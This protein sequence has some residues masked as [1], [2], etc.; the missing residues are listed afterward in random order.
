MNEVTIKEAIDGLKSKAFTS[1]GLTKACLDEIKKLDGYLKA[2]IKVLEDSSLEQAKTADKQIEA[3]GVEAFDAQLLLGIPYVCKDNYSTLGIETTAASNILKGYIPP[4]ESTVTERLKKSGAILLGKTNLDAFGH[5][6]TTDA[7]DFFVSRNPWDLTRVPGGSSGGSAVAVASHLCT[8]AIGSDTGGSIRCPAS[9][10]GVTGL[11]P[12]YGRVS[13]Y[14][15][16]AMASSTDSPGPITKNV[17]DSALLLGVLAGHDPKDATSSKDVV[18]D[19]SKAVG[20]FDIKKLRIGV[21]RSYFEIDFETPEIKNRIM[22]GI[23]LL[24]KS[25]AEVREIDLLHPKYAVAV[26]TVIQRSE[27][28]SNLARF[29][30][31]RFGCTRDVFGYEAKRRMMLGTYTLSAGYYD[32]YYAKA[33]KVRTL[34]IDGFN[35][36]FKD[37]DVIV[38]PTLPNLPVPIGQL[39]S[40]PIFGEL[41]DMLQ[42]P[43]SMA[44]LPVIS[45]PCGYAKGFPVGMQI[46]GPHF[47]EGKVLSI[48]KAFQD[49]TDFHLQYPSAIKE[50]K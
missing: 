34:I 29:D 47:A 33:Q 23:D 41:I 45:V 44:G 48:A 20:D 10:C 9:W 24:K 11:K 5:G 36:A 13:R 42:I 14:G 21:P 43:G 26:Y 50:F 39:D 37:V 8:F 32:E 30:G 1:Y 12:S 27:V 17:E 16:I 35:K 28:S 6:G 25:G 15:L 4:Y 38:G 3:R 18:D 2:F 46:I 31:I 49:S 7:S 22:E 19:Y 40:S